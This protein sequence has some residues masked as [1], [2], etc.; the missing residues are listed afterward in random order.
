MD[1]HIEVDNDQKPPY[2]PLFQLSPAE[3]SATKQYI[4]EMIENEKIRPSK[5]PYGAP[6][7]FVKEKENKL[8]AVID[9][10]GLNRI[11]KKNRTPLPRTDE[12]FDRLGGAKYFTK[13]DL[14]TGFNQIRMNPADIEKTAFNTKY[15]Q[16]EYL[17]MPMGLCNAPATFQS[18][19]NR[20]YYDCIDEFLVIYVDDLLIYSKSLEEHLQH[21]EIVLKRLRENKLYV[22]PKKCEFAKSELK[23]LGL[24]INQEGIQVDTSKIDVIETWPLPKNITELPS[25][26]GVLQFF[27]RFIKDFSKIAL[28]LTNLTRKGKS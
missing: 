27:R 4:V 21:L 19:M 24:I 11:T 6:L 17:V 8:R 5:S 10:R 15:G 16:Y 14:K 20:I 23:F 12:M 18:L 22:S 26:L 7:F 2:R 1:H 25:F 3:L 28:P 9:Y 13:L